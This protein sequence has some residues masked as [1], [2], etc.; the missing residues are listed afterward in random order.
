MLNYGI[1]PVRYRR[2]LHEI[3][4]DAYKG[5]AEAE[6]FVPRL[7]AAEKL[8]G[9]FKTVSYRFKAAV[10]K[11]LFRKYCLLSA[12]A[13]SAG[14]E[15]Q[16]ELHL[17]ALLQYYNAFESYPRRAL[18]YLRMARDFEE[19]LIP[20]AGPSYDVQ[21]GTLMN[22]SALLVQTLDAFD[23]V[24]ERD[25]LADV[26]TELALQMKRKD[27]RRDAVERLF[28]LNRG[29]LQQKG[30][31]LPATLVISGAGR[32]TERTLRNLVKTAGVDLS[33]PPAAMENRYTLTLTSS[34]GGE[35]RCELYD[36]GRG[37]TIFRRNI[38]YGNSAAEKTAFARLLNDAIFAGL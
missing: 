30:L 14:Q 35:I 19:P 2:D 21:E 6:A 15:N 36:G 13:Y 8:W 11:Q 4:W 25:M 5:L 34:D 16:G 23:P 22:N 32:R 26:Y 9:A 12:N 1:D 27:A 29:A 17:D 7:G 20:P 33:A 18:V 24:W 31:R 28:A 3:L 38:S 10:H 37:T